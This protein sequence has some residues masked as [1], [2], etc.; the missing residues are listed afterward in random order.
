MAG[1]QVGDDGL[2]AETLDRLAE[3][4]DVA[5][6]LRHLLG[7]RLDHAVVHPDPRQGAA[8]GRLGLGHLVLV[9]REYEVGAPS[10]NRE[11]NFAQFGFGHR[12]AFDVPTRTTRSPGRIPAGVLVL[13]VTLPQREVERITLERAGV[14]FTLFHVFRGPVR[15]LSVAVEASD[16]EVDVPAGLVGMPRLDQIGDQVVDRLAR[17]RLGVRTADTE[18][19]GVL[20][21]CGGH[22]PGQLGR[23]D[24]PLA[25]G[26]GK[27]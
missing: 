15:E 17:Q 13:L 25:R 5:L 19:A 2:K 18:P 22:L 4:E 1:D 12:R 14:V 10:M 27:I 16:R 21:V 11:R 26:G 3:L 9:V 20:E 7:V 23:L 6:G 24:P 8:A